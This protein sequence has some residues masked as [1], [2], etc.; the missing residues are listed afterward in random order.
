MMHRLAFRT[1]LTI[2]YTTILALALL[3]F[4][5]IAFIAIRLTLNAQLQSRIQTTETAIRSVP[6][7]RHGQV[8]FDPDDRAQFLEMLAESHV[9]GVTVASDGRVLLSNVAHPPRELLAALRGRAPRYGD[10]RTGAETLTFAV[11]P[12]SQGNRSYG[13]T[14]VWSSQ[15]LADGAARSALV[16]L[17]GATLALIVIAG[18]FGGWLARRLL[19][20]VADLSEL[21][22]DI[23]AT[24]LS[25]RLAW[26][27]PDDE[28][29]RLCTTFDRLL[30]RLEYAFDHQRRFTA[31]ASHELRT[32][33][34]VMRAEIE[35]ALARERD[36]GDYRRALQRLQA[37]TTRLEA[38]IE[39]LLLT[40]RGASGTAALQLVSLDEIARRAI[41][42]MTTPAQLARVT[43][44]LDANA[45]AYAL[46]DPPLI[47]SA[48]LALVDN[49]IHHTPPGGSV[50]VA[51]LANDAWVQLSVAD[52]GS[53]FSERALLEA[54]QRFWRDDP[55]RSGKGM[56]LGLSI[57]HAIAAQ[58][59][60]RIELRN[61]ERAGAV[62]DLWLPRAENVMSRRQ[63]HATIT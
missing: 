9:N 53:G 14:A 17:L 39:S 31:D 58:H 18:L 61:D 54:T 15:E 23:E 13:A 10:L 56:G 44:A 4:S 16:A 41:D 1:R 59:D 24:D 42:R 7:I 47:E 32:P 27:G 3:L 50:R 57:A 37:E 51:V 48:T 19:R 35:L 2:A 29:G 26:T 46:A 30:D 20:P 33:I 28:L 49:A 43:L 55:A 60:G 62:V 11:E 5:G 12:I 63:V 22:S 34:S 25:E 8:V 45:D 21:I 40:A 38:L 6:D 52:S 36:A